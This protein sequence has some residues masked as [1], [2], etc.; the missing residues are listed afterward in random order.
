MTD[1]ELLAFFKTNHL[2]FTLHHHEAV[3]S[4]KD[5]CEAMKLIPGA[6]SKNLFL[7]D[8]KGNFVLV[9]I[10]EHKRLDLKALSEALDLGRFS[11]CNSDELL[12]YLGVIPGSVTPYGLI[13]DTEN[14]V[15]YF[16]DKDFLEY[17]ELNFHPLRNDQTVTMERES[18]LSFFHGINHAP[19]AISIPEA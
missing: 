12:L 11:F 16:L 14:R 3:F 5:E 9:S 6:H 8:K 13:H 10:L 15:R 7:K 19:K 2:K 1:L 4:A 18:F 17:D